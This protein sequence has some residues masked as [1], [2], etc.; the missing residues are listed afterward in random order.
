[1]S[2]FLLCLLTTVAAGSVWADEFDDLCAS[3][4][5]VTTLIGVVHPNTSDLKGGA[6]NFWETTFE[7]APAKTA[8][9][10]N[11]HMAQADAAGNVYIAD[12]AGQAVLKISTDGKVHT[13][14][15]T[16]VPGFDTDGPAPATKLMLKNPNGLYVLP[17]GIVYL[18]DPD[19]HR[20][21]RVAEDGS[22]STVVNDPDPHWH[23]SGRALWVSPDEKLIYYTNETRIAP[24]DTATDGA[25]VKK[26]TPD[27]GI[28]IVCS[29]A[30]G[31]RNPGNIAVNP[32]DGKLY[33]T[34]R[35]E[36]DH[37]KMACGVFRI[38]GP[39]QRTRLVG[40]VTQPPANDGMLAANSFIDQPRGIAFLP[41]GAYFLCA[42]KEGSIWY[43][44]TGGVLHR[45]IRGRGNKD[46]YNLSDGMRPP[47]RGTARN[48]QEWF[49]Q[50]RS[51]TVAPNGDL[52][53]VC[54]DSGFVFK[55]SRVA[56]FPPKA[57]AAPAAPV[58]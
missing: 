15:G 20:I 10:S 44:D 33:V 28:E 42:H 58:K 41:N 36:D 55:V 25:V 53:A 11:P 27:K 50:P 4:G 56:P 48:G 31:F 14:A 40:N 51:V 30:V 23:G 47:L 19:N 43:V 2:K 32:V 39:D 49:S 45:Y 34:D 46:Y 57:P 3:Y 1:M 8:P 13:F 38:D 12:K 5:T 54:T 26:W 17:N 22:M 7:G 24:P 16:H 52:L 18:L 29:K 21:R 6:A 9:L 37:S 35:A